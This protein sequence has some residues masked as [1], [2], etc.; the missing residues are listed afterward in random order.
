MTSV[1]S[2]AADVVSPGKV[3]SLGKR[4]AAGLLD[5]AVASAL[6]AVVVWQPIRLGGAGLPL[7]AMVAVAI[8]YF[9]VPQTTFKATLM[10]RIFGISLVGLDG[11]KPDG[12]DV[13][14]RELLGRGLIA[15]PFWVLLGLS[16]HGV[17]GI[18]LA[19]PGKMGLILFIALGAV[20]VGAIAGQILMLARQDHRSFA[21]LIG[22][23]VVI[24]RGT[25][26]RR[27]EDEI[28]DDEARVLAARANSRRIRS[29]II[30][31][32]ILLGGAVLGPQLFTQPT[33]RR[34]DL[35]TFAELK[36]AE[37]AY[38][39]DVTNEEN[40]QEYI[41]L[42]NDSGDT[43]KAEA[44]LAAHNAALAEKAKNPDAHDYLVQKHR[45]NLKQYPCDGGTAVKLAERMNAIGA[46]APALKFIEEFGA[47]CEMNY[48]LRWPAV[49]AHRKLGQ[50]DQAVAQ[51]TLLIEARPDDSDYWWW[52][53][54]DYSKLGKRSAAD[55]D[56]R[57]SMAASP[58]EFAAHRF[59]ELWEKD[60]P[61]EASLALRAY[62]T[63][64]PD[65]DWAAQK[66]TDLELAGNCKPKSSGKT[67]IKLNPKGDLVEVAA[68][69][70]NQRAKLVLY[71]T[72]YVTLTQAFATKA[73]ITPS[74][75]EV[76]VFAGG[77]L[78]PAKL[79]KVSVMSVGEARSTE[80]PVAI[81]ET[82]PGEVDGLLGNSFMWRFDVERKENT[83]AL[84]APQ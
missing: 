34:H 32:V 77:K 84:H 33:P 14:Q 55:S 82:L 71:S 18:T 43:E 26:P 22:K 17:A 1:A 47:S 64:S 41:Q 25:E 80:V 62:L 5:F 8:A 72:G 83:L 48:R 6:G 49:V 58:N 52:R 78:T 65:A 61:C 50:F 74:S 79:A 20:V 44:I 40:A 21:D 23:T 38:N 51:N 37:R 45:A 9:V 31:E 53:G 24:E 2:T 30:I 4:F 69:V 81:V 11:R 39:E 36:K 70:E 66:R 15:W 67:S 54:E 75:E 16:N 68:K 7:I 28:D 46:H 59:A 76:S 12:M 60:D 19:T 42:L 13:L 27:L 10:M 3:A 35:A 63:V 73:G 29:F 56:F 57:H